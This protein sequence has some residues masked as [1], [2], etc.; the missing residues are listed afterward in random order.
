VEDHPAVI[1]RLE[2]RLADISGA[3][4]ADSRVLAVLRIAFG[5]WVIA[6]PVDV[7]WIAQVPSAFFHA[8]P[9]LFYFVPGPP[10]EWFLIGLMVAIAI[11]GAMLA[12]GV[13]TLPVS[14]A[15]SAALITSSG[16][17]YSYSK[18]DHFMLFEL[19]P[20]FLVFAGWGGTWSV[21]AYFRRRKTGD[22]APHLSNGMPLLLFAMTI[23]WA[24]L[25]AAAPKLAGGWLDPG[26]YASRG[27]LARDIVQGEKL[28]PLGPLALNFD[29]NLLWKFLDYS[30]LIAEGGLILVV[31]FPTV[32]RIWLILLASFHVGVYLTLGISFVD[33]VLVYAVFFSPFYIWLAGKVTSVLHASKS[34]RSP[35]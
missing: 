13:A 5:I 12:I 8:R 18:V 29:S 33:F 10:N 9:G 34:I 30:T 28:G 3:Y 1:S 32:F 26:R 7:T 4:A 20:I 21:D 35:S 16:L 6:F 25:S 22:Q 2:S 19:V 27:Y 24:M 23:G 17:S 15:L 11:L 31:F 14:I